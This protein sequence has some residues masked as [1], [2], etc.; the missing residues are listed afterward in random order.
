M[1]EKLIVPHHVHSPVDRARIAGDGYP[2]RE[3]ERVMP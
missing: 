3:G 1:D 2:I